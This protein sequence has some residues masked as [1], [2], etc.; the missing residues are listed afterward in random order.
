MRKVIISEMVSLDGFYARPNG[1]ID[2]FVVDDGFFQY[3]KDL[4]AQVDTQ[5]YG[6]VT[7]EGMESYW[8]TAQ[9]AA[10]NDPGITD[11]MNE[12]SKVVFSKTLE[13]VEWK[14]SRLA[15]NDPAEEVARLK[16]EPGKDMVIYGSGRLVQTLMKHGLID[17]YQIIVC[18]VILGSGKPLFSDINDKLNLTLLKTTVFDCGSVLFYYQPKQA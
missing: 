11:P 4:L 5:L 13:K 10:E 2:W 14:N 16:S 15:N 1:D 9:A 7:Y 8:I 17:E 3:A 6:R 12:M 18:P